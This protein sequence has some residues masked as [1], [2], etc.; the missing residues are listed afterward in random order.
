MDRETLRR[1]W[2]QVAASDAS[3]GL[4]IQ[5]CLMKALIANTNEKNKLALN[6]IYH[7]F[8]PITNATKL[9]NGQ[10]PYEAVK[11]ALTWVSV[12]GS[13][14]PLYALLDAETE[15]AYLH[16]LM[17][18]IKSASRLE[19]MRRDDATC[20]YLYVRNDLPPEQITIQV[21]HL[22]YESGYLLATMGAEQHPNIIVFGITSEEAMEVKLAALPS[23]RILGHVREEKLGNVMTG[24]VLKPML[25][26]VGRRKKYFVDD[27]LMT[28]INPERIILV[29]TDEVTVIDVAVT[30]DVETE[31]L[32]DEC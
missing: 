15:T 3:A 30:T 11:D 23:T 7:S 25:A 27:Q 16:M 6:M 12:F 28:M 18:I 24:F 22:T 10:R 8:T 21:A 17:N 20:L 32:R 31:T 5:Y 26:S 13:K 14:S 19:K 9:A 4:Q 2:K 29:S 1:A